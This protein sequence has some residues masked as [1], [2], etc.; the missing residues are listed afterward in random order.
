[1]Y[2]ATASSRIHTN[3]LVTPKLMQDPGSMAGQGC[4]ST[5]PQLNTSVDPQLS[6]DDHSFSTIFNFD[7]Y[8]ESGFITH[9]PGLFGEQSIERQHYPGIIR[10]IEPR[11][12]AQSSRLFTPP[13]PPR[14][15]ADDISTPPT[16]SDDYIERASSASS[17]PAR[18]RTI[19]PK[20]GSVTPKQ[21][22]SHIDIE[23][24]ELPSVNSNG[25]RFTNARDAELFGLRTKVNLP[26]DDWE[27][28]A[29]NPEPWV[30]QI[31]AA[32]DK[33]PIKEAVR[34][35]KD[36]KTIP[37]DRW[38]AFQA[39]HVEKTAVHHKKNKAMLEIG[40]WQVF[41]GI[42]D[43]HKDG[44][45]MFKPESA[46]IC[47]EHMNEAIKAIGDYAIIRFDVVRCQGIENMAS[48]VTATIQ[49][50]LNCCNGNSAKK[51]REEENAKHAAEDGAEWYKAVLGSG[52]KSNGGN[53]KRKRKNSE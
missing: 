35:S 28:V 16:S 41:Q 4:Y 30:K 34:H 27:A 24:R 33:E 22:K 2:R 25:L 39:N 26:G 44:Y 19:R 49:R 8:Q 10:F 9:R 3:T 21:D 29:A 45:P 14:V 15:R 38:A 40:A 23:H 20:K 47:S 31:I 46:K 43:A 37:E 36:G 13:S 53:N 7:E 52:Q 48:S 51:A 5:I 32:F 18:R 50:K 11:P 42:I 17:S 1:M 6:T 12:Y